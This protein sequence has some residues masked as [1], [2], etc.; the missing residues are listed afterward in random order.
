MKPIRFAI[1]GGG[2]RCESYV[3]AAKALPELFEITGVLVRDPDK[4]AAFAAKWG[5]PVERDLKRLLAAQ[6]EFVFVVVPWEPA[7]AYNLELAQRGIPVL[8]ETPPAPDVQGL[9]RLTDLTRQGARI[10]VAEQYPFQPLMAARIAVAQSGRLGRV[11]SCV[12]SACHGY[13][14]VALMR[15]FLGLGFENASLTPYRFSPAPIVGGPGRSGPPMEEKLN[16][17]TREFVFFRF[18]TGQD[19]LFD[20]DGAQYFS[21]ARALHL[22]V[23]GERGE[24]M[25]E[26][27]RTQPRF[28]T[29]LAEPLQRVNVGEAGNLEGYFL[30]GYT[31]GGHYVYR[32]PFPGARLS[33]DEL[34][35]ATCLMKMGLY[36]RGGEPFYGVEQAAQDMYMSLLM[37]EALKTGNI[38]TSQTQ[39]WA[40]R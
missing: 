7:Y 39:Q 31:L 34:A 23:Q 21:W 30:R 16:A 2:W 24:I 4:G 6:P 28:D 17:H 15:K 37:G 29:P 35:M 32:N 36:V 1:I 18:E 10:Q 33:D 25:D 3:T 9:E 26:M 8:S 14:F 11:T 20:F 13:H 27:V 38:K 22:Q 12:I 19:A 40:T 5:V